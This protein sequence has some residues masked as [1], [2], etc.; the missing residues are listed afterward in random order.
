[1]NLK[2][3]K[4]YLNTLTVKKLKEICSNTISPGWVYTPTS[5]YQGYSRLNKSDLIDCMIEYQSRHE[6]P[7]LDEKRI[8][9]G[10]GKKAIYI[11]GKTYKTYDFFLE[12]IIRK[13]L[14]NEEFREERW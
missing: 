12:G 4:E 7:I 13:A 6:K 9:Q 8:D 5:V 1:M 10:I 3:L 14:V 11:K 2:E